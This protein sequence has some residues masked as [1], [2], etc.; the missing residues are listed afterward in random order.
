MRFDFTILI[1]ALVLGATQID[2][3]EI[4]N[5]P[6][7]ARE[8]IHARCVGCHDAD[9]KAGGL[10]LTA[11]KDDAADVEA[12]AHWVRVHDRV[13]D[14][15]MPPEEKLSLEE[16]GKLLRPLRIVLSQADRA[17]RTGRSTPHRSHPQLP[18]DAGYP[19]RQAAMSNRNPQT[20]GL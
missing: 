7:T 15:E 9:T 2:A 11:L 10:D 13:R 6:A 3:S 18:E 1:A 8:L 12:F 14:G 19:F 16:R 4:P 20:P 17:R 5:L